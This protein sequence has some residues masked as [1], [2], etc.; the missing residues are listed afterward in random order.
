VAVNPRDAKKFQRAC[1]HL[2]DFEM[3]HAIGPPAAEIVWAVRNAFADVPFEQSTNLVLDRPTIG[4]DRIPIIQPE[5]KR[6]D[7]ACFDGQL[8][9]GVKRLVDAGRI[10]RVTERQ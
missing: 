7:E 10:L 2:L 3:D 4:Q 8:L 9:F 5:P 1:C 6:L